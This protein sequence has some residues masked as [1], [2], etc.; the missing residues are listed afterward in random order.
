MV[1]K[2]KIVILLF[3][4]YT[5]L[6]VVGPFEVLSKIPDSKIY[7]VALKPGMQLRNS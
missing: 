3:D 7:M 1:G 5:A 2:Y 6:D 4:N